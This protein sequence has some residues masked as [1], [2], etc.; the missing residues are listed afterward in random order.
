[1]NCPNDIKS[2]TEE[3]AKRFQEEAFN[4]YG[5]LTQTKSDSVK[6][7][8]LT[9]LCLSAAQLGKYDFS[10]LMPVAMALEL[11]ELAVARH[12]INVG[13]S[14][15][16][17]SPVFFRARL[18]GEFYQDVK[19]Q[20]NLPLIAGDYYYARAIMLVA[21]LG[22]QVVDALAQ[23]IIDISQGK[24]I[25]IRSETLT[26]QEVKE[27]TEAVK[28]LAS[29]YEVACYLGGWLSGISGKELVDIKKLGQY[30][31]G[32]LLISGAT[33]ERLPF[34]PDVLDKIRKRFVMRVERIFTS[35]D[36]FPCAV[37]LKGVFTQFHLLSKNG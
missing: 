29:L 19:T 17:E 11:L 16:K 35:F 33:S 27:S 3:I 10:R 4:S 9:Q 7:G 8:T 1:M 6:Y 20:A 14:R 23:S 12:Y 31:G 37:S 22:P 25:N 2:D 5:L 18:N 34:P 24:F 36:G 28:K 26:E 30:F 15:H 13:K 21:P 32:L